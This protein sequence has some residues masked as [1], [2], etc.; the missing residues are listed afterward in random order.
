MIKKQKAINKYLKRIDYN[1]NICTRVIDRLGDEMR[2]V[3]LE[4]IR[5]I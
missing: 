4:R 5:N 2:Y 3:H 1:G